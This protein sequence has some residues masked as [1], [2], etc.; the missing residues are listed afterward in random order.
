MKN[1]KYYI[2]LDVHKEHTTYVVRDK[3]GN[4]LLENETA[5]LYSELYPR[6]KPYLATSLIGLEAS[7]SYYT[8]YQTF[9]KNNYN[10]KVANT[11][12]LRQ[13]I[14]KNDKLD[15]KRLSEML[16]LGTFPCSY[17]PNEKIQHLRSLIDAKRLSE[18]LR[19]GTFPCSYIPNEKIQHLRSL[20]QVRHSLMEEKV[21]CNARIQAFIDKNGVMMPPQEAFSKHWRQTLTKHLITGTVSGELQYEYDHFLFLEK[22]QRQVEQEMKH[23]THI[24]W[25]KEYMLIQSVTGFGPVLACY[26]IAN[27]CPIERFPSNRKLRRYAGVIP[28][29][30]Q[31]GETISKGHIP[32]GSSRKQLRWALVQAANTAGR[33]DTPLGRY[34]RKKKKQKKI[35]AIAK[36]AVA[37]SMI[38]I[39][40]KVLTTKQPYQ[41]NMVS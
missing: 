8:L 29:T 3:I 39:L 10:I 17:I 21:R 14:T 27:V 28:V 25:K 38:D 35:T 30:K 19:L 31:S 1:I 2:G 40:Y 41:P 4:I 13:L 5:T 23:Y 9:L 18:M 22:K 7:T 11:I 32:K 26:I 34:Y 6:L 24:N 37:S 33:T 12:Q 15:A 20:V 16:R 36:I